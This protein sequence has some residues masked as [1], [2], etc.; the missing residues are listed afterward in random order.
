MIPEVNAAASG[1]GPYSFS[2]RNTDTDCYDRLHLSSLFSFMQEAAYLN[3]EAGG[4]GASRL[5][6]L[7]LCWMLI[8]ISIRMERLP[9]WGDTLTVVTWS[10][11]YR[12]LT[13]LRD[14]E[15]FNEAGVRLGCGTS[16]WLVGN[17]SDHRPQRP[18]LALPDQPLPI[19]ERAVFEGLLSRPPQLTLDQDSQPTLALYADFSDIDRNR[20]VNNTRYV[21]WCMNAIHALVRSGREE[22]ADLQVSGLDIHYISEVK[23]G[24]KIY[25]YAQTEAQTPSGEYLVEAR[26]AEDGSTVFRARVLT[27]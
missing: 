8:R 14:Y 9:H 2:I 21:A 22:P 6:R 7:G 15:F 3:A 18:E 25:C 11:G 5:D 17:A 4:L 12:K 10:R 27:A 23:I 20:H 16:E 19:S 1:F 26:R 24:E 13:W